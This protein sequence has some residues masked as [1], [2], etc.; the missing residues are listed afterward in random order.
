[1]SFNLP[2][3]ISSHITVVHCPR[4]LYIGSSLAP[5]DMFFFGEDS[6]Q[7]HLGYAK[8]IT[9]FPSLMKVC[10]IINDGTHHVHGC[11]NP[12]TFDLII[13]NL[14][15]IPQPCP[16]FKANLLKNQRKY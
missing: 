6:D 10:K 15:T 14:T 5:I 12:T 11:E 7:N 8:P 16:N 1:M 2:F 9:R 3:P 13:L 4:K